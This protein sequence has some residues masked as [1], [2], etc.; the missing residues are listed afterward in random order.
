MAETVVDRRQFGRHGVRHLRWLLLNSDSGATA[1]GAGINQEV[2][3][4]DSL[5][6]TATNSG[7]IGVLA[8]A[9]VDFVAG[10][11]TS[12]AAF[13]AGVSQELG[14]GESAVASFVN[15]GSLSVTASANN[16]FDYTGMAAAYSVAGASARTFPR[17]KT[18]RSTSRTRQ[19]R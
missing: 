7:D 4:A 16:T 19:G 6:A 9:T 18:A 3:D 10:T 1:F 15:S 14:Y 11:Y 12:A 5:S 2:Y 8:S 13:G 17:S